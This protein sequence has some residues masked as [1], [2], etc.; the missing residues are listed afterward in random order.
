MKRRT[1]L[2]ITYITIV[3]LPLTAALS[4][5]FERSA[6]KAGKI[7]SIT[8][9]SAACYDERSDFGPRRSVAIEYTPAGTDESNRPWPLTFACVTPDDAARHQVG[10]RYP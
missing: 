7:T 10:G 3:L 6:P 2:V 5:D 1:R 9:D 8:P 4:C